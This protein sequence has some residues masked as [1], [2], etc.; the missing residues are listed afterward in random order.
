MMF[1]GD[2]TMPK[3]HLC[4]P[5]YLQWPF[6]PVTLLC[7]HAGPFHPVMGLVNP[8]PGW[9]FRVVCASSVCTMACQSSHK[10]IETEDKMM[11]SWLL[12]GIVPEW[13]TFPQEKC[14]GGYFLGEMYAGFFWLGIFQGKCLWNVQR[15]CLGWVSIS[16]SSI[17]RLYILQL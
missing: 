8:L 9:G 16:A 13:V 6:L 12:G 4:D 1:S 15:N 10:S 7:L 2:R 3:V 11:P 14:S 17:T 5:F